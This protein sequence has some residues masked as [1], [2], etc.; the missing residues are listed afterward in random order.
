MHVARVR[1][2]ST[3]LRQNDVSQQT[4]TQCAGSGLLSDTHTNLSSLKRMHSESGT[5]SLHLYAFFGF[6]LAQ[7]GSCKFF[8]SRQNCF[9]CQIHIVPSRNSMS[10]NSSPPRLGLRLVSG[11]LY[12]I[13]L[14]L[15]CGVYRNLVKFKVLY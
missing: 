3:F 7:T 15:L 9:V 1:D 11:I 6:R 14:V 10:G 5:N 12:E 4:H 8:G 13:G 2:V